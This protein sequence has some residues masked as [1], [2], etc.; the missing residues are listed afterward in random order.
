LPCGE[1]GLVS[2]SV[3]AAAELRGDADAPAGIA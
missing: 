1:V 2:A 3:E